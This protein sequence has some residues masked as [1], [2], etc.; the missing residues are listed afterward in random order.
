MISG[1]QPGLVE[2]QQSLETCEDDDNRNQAVSGIHS[3]L[4]CQMNT[5]YSRGSKRASHPRFLGDLSSHITSVPSLLGE[6]P[7]PLPRVY[8]GRDDLVEKVTR[9]V[10]QLAPV[11]LIGVSGIGKTS[12]TLTVLRDD[13][14]KHRFSRERRFTRCEF[15]GSQV[16]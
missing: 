7:P 4:R 2:I 13:C 10:E 8:S 15:H 9:C 6:P 5:N 12:I 16:C 3:I 14:V 11:V 1:L